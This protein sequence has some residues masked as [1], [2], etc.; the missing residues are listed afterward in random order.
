MGAW[1]AGPFEND[2]AA[3]WAAEFDGADGPQ[4]LAILRRAL[5]SVETAEYVE[6]PDG[7]VAVAATQVVAWLVKP[8]SIEESAYVES[9]VGWLRRS[10]PSIDSALVEAARRA[11]V[12]MRAPDSE[13]HELWIEAED[14]DWELDLDRIMNQLHLA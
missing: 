1:G 12:R 4:G 7:S 8:D 13:L 6:A 11:L 14:P 2:D 5:S 3:D 9:V 10:E